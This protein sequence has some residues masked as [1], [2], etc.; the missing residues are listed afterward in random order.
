MA[1]VIRCA[2]GVAT[3]HRCIIIVVKVIIALLVDDTSGT[4]GVVTV[5]RAIPIVIPPVVAVFRLGGTVARAAALDIIAIGCSIV[6]VIP[7]V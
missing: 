2:V 4:I 1:A 3:I 5:D 7:T 6:I